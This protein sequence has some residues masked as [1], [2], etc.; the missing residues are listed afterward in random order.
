MS[1]ANP[2]SDAEREVL[3]VLW[4]LERATVREIRERLESRG[5]SWAH[6]TI[7]T[8]LTRME[9]KRMVVRDST[10]FAHVYSPSASRE[11]VVQQRLVDLADEFCDGQS[12]PLML[13]L[14]ENQRFSKEEIA[15][16]RELVD[17][18]EK[19]A[20]RSSKSRKSKKRN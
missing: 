19:Q 4:E 12:V 14:V 16:F 15:Q 7:S 1:P 10:G 8:L 6:T 3:K 17:R 13:A 9:Q 20:A 2:I 11:N 5:T 18:M